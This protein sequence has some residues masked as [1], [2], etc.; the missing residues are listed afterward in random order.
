MERYIEKFIRYL[1][2]EKNYSKHTILNYRLDL[3][4]FKGFLADLDL[5]KVDYLFL[6]KYLAQLKEKKLSNRSVNRHISS[7]RSFFRFLTREGLLKTN[8][9]VLLSSPKQ[10]KYLPLFLT[11]EEVSKLIEAALPKD[12]RGLR[13]RAILETFYSTGIR[14]SE[15]AGLSIED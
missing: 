2:I 4:G 11:E 15:L 3:L 1:E 8:P 13:D 10:E 9:I 5:E 14:I 7:L 6:R 12:E